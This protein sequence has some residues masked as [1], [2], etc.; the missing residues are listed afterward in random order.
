MHT[1]LGL[2]GRKGH[3]F[4]REKNENMNSTNMTKINGLVVKKKEK[5]RE[6]ERERA[7]ERERERERGRKKVR[8]SNG[9][10]GEDY[11]VDKPN[12]PRS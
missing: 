8:E 6:R 2:S 5:R 12:T 3:R 1:F 4:R 9:G 7:R 11:Q 10:K